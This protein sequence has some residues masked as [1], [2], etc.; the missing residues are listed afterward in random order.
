[1]KSR[2]RW[3]S[4]ATAIVALFLIAGAIGAATE[5]PSSLCTHGV[6]YEDADRIASWLRQRPTVCW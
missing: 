4:I 3:G 6:D 1:M 2:N 5:K